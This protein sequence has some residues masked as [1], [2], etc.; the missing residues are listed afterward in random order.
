MVHELLGAGATLVTETLCGLLLS[1]VNIHL[2]KEGS[3]K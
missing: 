3:A 1:V 2:L